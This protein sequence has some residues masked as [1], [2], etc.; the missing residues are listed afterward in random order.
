MVAAR[1]VDNS[2]IATATYTRRPRNRTETEVQRLR[3][4]WQQKLKR[5]A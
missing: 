3:H 1:R 5:E 4:R 2:T